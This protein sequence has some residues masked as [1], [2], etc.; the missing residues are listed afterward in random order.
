MLSIVRS[1]PHRPVVCWHR[2]P[3]FTVSHR[4]WRTFADINGE[5]INLDILAQALAE[6]TR[7]F[8][9]LVAS[10]ASLSEAVWEHPTMED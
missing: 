4:V 5:D 1:K 3:L 7:A 9:W 8:V 10:T 2:M 6:D